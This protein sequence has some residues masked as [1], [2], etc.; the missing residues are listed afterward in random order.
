MLYQICVN[1]RLLGMRVQNK[2][3]YAFLACIFDE[4]SHTCSM[5]TRIKQRRFTLSRLIQLNKVALHF[6]GI[7]DQN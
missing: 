3:L 1:V 5:H 2:R 6:L 7:F 4:N